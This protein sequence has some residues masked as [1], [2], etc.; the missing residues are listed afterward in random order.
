LQYIQVYS[1][2]IKQHSLSELRRRLKV[3]LDTAEASNDGGA[4]VADMKCADD[5]ATLET[6]GDIH[7]KVYRLEDRMSDVIAKLASERGD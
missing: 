6:K 5:P 4:F 3:L 7:G 1:R 2:G